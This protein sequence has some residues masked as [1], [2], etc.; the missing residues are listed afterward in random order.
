MVSS[1]KLGCNSGHHK[2]KRPHLGKGKFDFMTFFRFKFPHLEMGILPQHMEDN[3]HFPCTLYICF[4][5]SCKLTLLDS[6][7]HSLD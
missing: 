7:N 3:L 6:P 2:H 1:N 5:K 4:G